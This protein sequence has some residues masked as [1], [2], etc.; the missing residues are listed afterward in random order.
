MRKRDG[1]LV[2]AT[3][4]ARDAPCVIMNIVVLRLAP[5]TRF[6]HL[7]S[8]NLVLGAIRETY[9]HDDARRVSCEHRDVV[10]SMHDTAQ[11][12]AQLC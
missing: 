11:I 3:M 2:R 9:V 5:S 7:S 8:Q 10:T 4:F 12:I 6:Y 1:A